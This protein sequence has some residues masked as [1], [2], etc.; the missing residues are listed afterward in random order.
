MV[1]LQIAFDSYEFAASINFY[2]IFFV[3]RQLAMVMRITTWLKEQEISHFLRAVSL[4]SHLS[5]WNMVVIQLPCKDLYL[6]L[7]I[8]AKT[9][10]EFFF[11]IRMSFDSNVSNNEI[12]LLIS[13]QKNATT[14]IFENKNEITQRIV[15]RRCTSNW[16]VWIVFVK[17][18]FERENKRKLL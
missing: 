9:F 18:N 13:K 3:W 5:S 1:F 12:D 11:R 15:S 17:F 2:S 8:I 6:K 4:L 10:W 7:C 16:V 14:M